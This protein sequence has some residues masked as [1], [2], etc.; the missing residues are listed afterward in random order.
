MKRSG[1]LKVEKIGGTSMSMF[2]NI[3]DNIIL[4]DPQD[5]FCRIY[6]VSAYGGITNDLLEHKKSGKTGIYKKFENHG[7]YR[8][9]LEVLKKK[10]YKIN[11]GFVSAGLNLKVANQFVSER[12]DKARSRAR[13]KMVASI[14]RAAEKDWKAAAWF[15]ERSSPDDWAR[16][17]KQDVTLGGDM[18]VVIRREQS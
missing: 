10:L 1:Q 13:V 17:S 6:V 18:N 15:L 14:V 9:A 4:R 2:G 7:N 16:R 5:V 12:I 11:K 8:A 3:V